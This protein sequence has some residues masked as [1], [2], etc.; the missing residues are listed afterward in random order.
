MTA[1]MSLEHRGPP[2]PRRRE[3]RLA[4]EECHALLDWE[5]ANGV[6]DP[7]QAQDPKTGNRHKPELDCQE[8]APP[9]LYLI[10]LFMWSSFPFLFRSLPVCVYTF[11]KMAGD[12]GIKA[13]SL[14]IPRFFFTTSYV[15]TCISVCISARL[16][17][18]RC[19][20]CLSARG[21]QGE[22]RGVAGG[23]GKALP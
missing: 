19:S 9:P 16:P 4:R 1:D 22:G 18:C 11:P 7:R 21:A 17:L 5:A 8:T 23:E 14:C 3:K 10:F 12:K 13:I 15:R 6:C 20:V 2:T